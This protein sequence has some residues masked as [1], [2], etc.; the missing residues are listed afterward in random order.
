MENKTLV[1]KGITK[2]FPGVL[3][4]HDVDFEVKPGEVVGL[5]GE[6]GAGKST[7]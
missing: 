7:L 4:L 5:M 1:M 6:N 2:S 3:A